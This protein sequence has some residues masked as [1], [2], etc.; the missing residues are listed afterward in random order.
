MEFDFPLQESGLSSELQSQLQ[1]DSLQS[2]DTP[3]ALHPIESGLPMRS[4]KEDVQR[5]NKV[6]ELME[7][8]Q[9]EKRRL[10]LNQLFQTQLY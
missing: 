8:L 6:L 10:E 3:F 9:K 4:E 5:S 7:S 1:L 2:T